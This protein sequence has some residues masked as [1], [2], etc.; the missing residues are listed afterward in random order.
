MTVFRF[1]DPPPKKKLGTP[2]VVIISFSP[3]AR[4]DAHD[5]NCLSNQISD[6]QT[7]D[8]HVVDQQGI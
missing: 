7:S 5:G 8:V 3:P 4:R 2:K 6:T 1:Y